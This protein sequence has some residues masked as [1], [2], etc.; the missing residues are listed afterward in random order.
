MSAKYRAVQQS[1]GS[2]WCV[3]EIAINAIIDRNLSHYN[4]IDFA[5]RLNDSKAIIN[6]KIK[7]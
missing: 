7:G 2:L 6:I 4:A 5:T 3:L 1:K